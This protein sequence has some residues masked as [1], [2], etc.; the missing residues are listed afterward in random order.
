MY[1]LFQS[2]NQISLIVPQAISARCSGVTAL[3]V[4]IL[5]LCFPGSAAAL[6]LSL[7]DVSSASLSAAILVTMYS[8]ANYISRT[9]FTFWAFWVYLSSSA[10]GSSHNTG[11]TKRKMEQ[12]DFKLEHCCAYRSFPVC[13]TGRKYSRFLFSAFSGRPE[14]DWKT[15]RRIVFLAETIFLFLKSSKI[16]HI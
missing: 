3:L 5:L 10:P 9:F 1:P 7:E 4:Q 8:S 15:I 6:F 11:A 13:S 2:S 16:S 12:R 14:Q